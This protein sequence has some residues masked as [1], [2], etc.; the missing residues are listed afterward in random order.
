MQLATYGQKPNYQMQQQQQ[1]SAGNSNA[2]AQASGGGFGL[3]NGAPGASG[4]TTDNSRLSFHAEVAR[5]SRTRAPFCRCFGRARSRAAE[6]LDL[7]SMLE[8]QLR[9]AHR[10]QSLPRREG[11]G[12]RHPRAAYAYTPYSVSDL[13]VWLCLCRLCPLG[14]ELIPSHPIA[15]AFAN[16]A[17]FFTYAPVTVDSRSGN[18]AFVAEFGARQRDWS[19]RRRRRPGGLLTVVC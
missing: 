8:P 19:W 18:G 9:M 2:A 13:C 15:S 7:R 3:Q 14:D 6:R 5:I 4:V 10:V 12:Q 1:R 17:H 16:T 11:G